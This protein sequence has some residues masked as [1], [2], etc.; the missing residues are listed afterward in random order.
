MAL[1][2]STD[3]FLVKQND[4]RPKIRMYLKQGAAGSVSPIDLT[5]ATAVVFNMR[6]STNPGTVV[7][8]REDA[9]I[10]TPATA[11]GVEYTLTAAQTATVGTYQAEFEVT[12]A[13]GGILT[14]PS[15]DDWI[16][17]R[18]GDDIA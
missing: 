16:Y 18:I 17:I 15:G 5:S 14:V 9:D 2:N 7:V 8:S 6:L 3:P 4:N 1:G 13:D 12:F 11:G 10:L